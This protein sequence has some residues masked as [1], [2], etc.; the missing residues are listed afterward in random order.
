MDGLGTDANFKGRQYIKIGDKWVELDE[1]LAEN[2][3]LKVKISELES[4]LAKA[5]G[6]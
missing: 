1:V 2:Q 5:E 4:K 6:F 3:A